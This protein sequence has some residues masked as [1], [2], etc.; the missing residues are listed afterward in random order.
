MKKV[1]NNFFV[2][3]L[4]TS[5]SFS[6]EKSANKSSKSALKLL[7]KLQ[8]QTRSLLFLIHTMPVTQQYTNLPK[9]LLVLFLSSIVDFSLSLKCST[10]LLN[11]SLNS[12]QKCVILYIYSY[13]IFN[14]VYLT[15][16]RCLNCDPFLSSSLGTVSCLY[17]LNFVYNGKLV[18]QRLNAR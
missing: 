2:R 13:A 8:K 17:F 5:N 14:E 4:L 11:V 7:S 16:F 15:V 18:E 12:L 6:F 1:L 9:F 10:H 3:L